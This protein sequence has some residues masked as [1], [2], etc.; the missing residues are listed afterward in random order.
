MC[1]LLKGLFGLR[2][3]GGGVEG[4]RVELAKIRLILGQFYYTLLPFPLLQSKRTI[5]HGSIFLS[6]NYIFLIGSL[7]L[8]LNLPLF[9]TKYTLESFFCV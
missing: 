9:S 3:K 7:F 1:I 6:L 2:G 8:S 4:S 5:N